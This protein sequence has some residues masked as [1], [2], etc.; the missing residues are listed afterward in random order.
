MHK[1]TTNTDSP[2]KPLLAE[3]PNFPTR[4]TCMLIITHACN[5]NCSYCYENFKSN[6]FMT[7]ELAKN[8]LE[9]E[10]EFIRNSSVYDSLS[11][12]FMGGEPM[13]NFKLIQQV[14]E[15]LDE[16]DFNIPYICFASTNGTLV[17]R[18]EEEWLFLHRD[19]IVFALS[20]DGDS[21][22]QNTNRS[23]SSYKIN[24]DFFK[25]TWP[26]QGYHMT[27]SK[28]TLQNL[29]KGV[30][31]LQ[32]ENIPLIAALAQG[33]DWTEDDARELR[34]QLR[35]LSKFYLEH[36][37]CPPFSMLTRPLFH[38]GDL[39]SGQQKYCGA[40]T[41]MVTYDVDGSVYPC[42]IF[43][44][45]VLGADKALEINNSNLNCSCNLN[46]EYCENCLLKHWCNTCYG[47]NYRDRGDIATRDHRWCFM[48]RE[49]AISCCEFQ[50]AY[51]HQH[52]HELSE[53]DYLQL[54]AAIKSHE[55][56]EKNYNN[57][58]QCL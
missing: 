42:H 25:K 5:L 35:I 43:T 49:W 52:I 13:T 55:L 1:L 17:G 54:N 46:D 38:L 24:V 14:V 10:F 48:M 21:N 50:I 15:W 45:L 33:I 36:S 6:K 47:F 37:D 12:D 28:E 32:K 56:F 18:K 8:I 19:K 58:R 53:S 20:Y 30:I 29:A 34:K 23:S 9:K 7:F 3:P 41:G 2:P 51:Y 11:I 22:M 39:A 4:R 40:G 27:I 26:Q 44:P 57:F 31:D 16:S